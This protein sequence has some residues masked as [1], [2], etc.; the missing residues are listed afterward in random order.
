MVYKKLINVLCRYA[1]Q[2]VHIWLI[3]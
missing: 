1:V 3:C 2:Y